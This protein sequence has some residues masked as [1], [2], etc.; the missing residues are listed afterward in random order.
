[1][2]RLLLLCLILS[3]CHAGSADAEVTDASSEDA[4]A[5]AEHSDAQLPRAD[6]AD[7][8]INALFAWP[9]PVHSPG[10]FDSLRSAYS[11]GSDFES[12][13]S[14]DQGYT[15]LF[16]APDLNGDGLPDAAILEGC[17][18][19]LCSASV[20]V[21]REDGYRYVGDI[22]VSPIT[23]PTVCPDGADSALVFSL[24]GRYEGDVVRSRVTA[25]T[26]YDAGTTPYEVRWRDE[27]DAEAGYLDIEDGFVPEDCAL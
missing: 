13:W 25:D 26:A 21:Q 20:F 3:A 10:A 7:L 5:V 27:A 22:T 1:M 23:A 8:A 14:I 11:G 2:A 4:H 19:A 24:I 16:G 15:D 12:N 18:I 6:S 9:P 17:G